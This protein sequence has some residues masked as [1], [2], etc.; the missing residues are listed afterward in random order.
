MAS[1]GD[2]RLCD[3]LLRVLMHV[4]PEFKPASSRSKACYTTCTDDGHLQVEHFWCHQG[5][6]GQGGGRAGGV[7]TVVAACQG[8][9]AGPA[10]AIGAHVCS[11]FLCQ[12]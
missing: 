11:S 7:L 2:K 1:G 4:L 3:Q 10:L 9:A 12:V 5:Q 6:Q 8:K